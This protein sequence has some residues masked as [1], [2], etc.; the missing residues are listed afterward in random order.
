M[1]RHERTKNEL[2][3]TEVKKC[4]CKLKMFQLKLKLKFVPSLG[5]L[6]SIHEYKDIWNKRERS[7]RG[8]C[9]CLRR[10]DTD[11]KNH[12]VGKHLVWT[13]LKDPSLSYCIHVPQERTKM[14]AS[15]FKPLYISAYRSWKQITSAKKVMFS[16]LSVVGLPAGLLKKY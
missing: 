8:W 11:S 13:H 7:D 4:P 12:P 1:Q 9:V 10:I 3:W 16:P 15:H 5:F 2:K 14:L 6:T